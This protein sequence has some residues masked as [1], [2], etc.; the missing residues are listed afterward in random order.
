M[1]RAVRGGDV[2]GSANICF[3]RVLCLSSGGREGAGGE[4]EMSHEIAAS[5]KGENASMKWMCIVL[6][7]ISGESGSSCSCEANGV[8][9]YTTVRAS[10]CSSGGVDGNSG[11]EEDGSEKIE[12]EGEGEGDSFS[13]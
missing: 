4:D 13:E 9:G 6:G 2:A 11:E 12:N 5:L 3:K 1:V 7:G 8:T 10:S